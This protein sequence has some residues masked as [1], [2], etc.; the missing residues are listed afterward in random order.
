M[1]EKKLTGYPSIDKPWLKYYSEEAIN[2]PLP[3]R[4]MYEYIFECNQDNLDRVAMN[5]YGSDMTYREMFRQIS[6]MAGTLEHYGVKKGETVTVCM[7]NAPETVCLMFALNKIGAVANMVYGSSTPEELKKYIIDVKSTLVFTL[8]MFQEKFV[9]IAE[10]AKL[11]KVVVT[12]ITESMS[13]ANRIGAR[14]FKGLKPKTLPKDKRFCGWNNFFCDR[15]E[16][17][18]TAHDPNASAII[19]YTGGTTGGSKGAILSNIAVCATSQQYI[20][21]EGKGLSRER[22]WMQVLPLFIAYGITC[23]LIITLAAGMKCVIRIPMTDSIAEL[24]KKF[25]PNYIIYGPAFWEKFADDNENIDLSNLCA[26]LCGG[27]T[28][29][30]YIEEKINKYLKR[31]GSPVPLLNGYAMTEIGAGGTLSYSHANKVGSV[32]IPLLKI[33][34][35]IFDPETEEELKY[36]QEGEVCI[37]SPSMMLGY[38]NNKEETDNIIRTHKD[39]LRWVHSGDLGYMDEDGFIYISGRLKRYF[40]YINEGIQKKIFSL[41]IE[42]VLLEHSYVGNCAVVPIADKETFQKPVAF[43]ISNKTCSHDGNLET[44]LK[45]FAKENLQEGYR[46]VKYIFMEKFP[47][48]K[49]GKVD[50]LTLE[51]IAQKKEFDKK[52]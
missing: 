10:D 9:Q 33:T 35:S 51:Q 13:F 42:K 23:S 5:Y 19:T 8:D 24:C 25:K 39:G 20:L 29:R 44:K 40:L 21:S 11:K 43:I 36:G 50:Y 4:T 46:P 31:C 17:T 52:D 38:I 41:D 12:N 32:G 26:T 6:I 30:P 37:H 14:L 7:I 48:T 34:I 3:E 2:A 1:K 15:Y 45:A 47:L 16:S 49:V 28:L 22:T 18:Y 27:D